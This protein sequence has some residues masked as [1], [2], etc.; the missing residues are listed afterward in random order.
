VQDASK[1]L[2]HPNHD[3]HSASRDEDEGR[4][5]NRQP[6]SDR[7]HAPDEPAPGNAHCP[8]IAFVLLSERSSG[9]VQERG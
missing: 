1:L 8:T 3:E 7:K 2:R 9:A 6:H 5:P 4:R